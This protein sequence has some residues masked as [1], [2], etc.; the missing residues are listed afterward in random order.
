MRNQAATSRFR[1]K[2]FLITIA[3]IFMVLL[4]VVYTVSFIYA[5]TP[6]QKQKNGAAQ[7]GD[8]VS[9]LNNN[10]ATPNVPTSD[11]AS[12]EDFKS[13]NS[14]DDTLHIPQDHKELKKDLEN[15][16]NEFDNEHFS[17]EEKEE[18]QKKLEA[19]LAAKQ[20]E[21]KNKAAATTGDDHKTQQK[22]EGS[23]EYGATPKLLD[24]AH[25]APITVGIVDEHNDVLAFWLRAA[26]QSTLFF[27]SHQNLILTKKNQ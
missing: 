7:M 15:I 2:S 10:D 4:G 19:E 12:T 23:D 14:N 18:L 22:N 13:P 8:A 25:A 26:K 27:F 16:T 24:R 3:V 20:L 6:S 21:A 17:E 11:Q 1:S 5:A 9:G